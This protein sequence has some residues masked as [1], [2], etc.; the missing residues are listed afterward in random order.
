MNGAYYTN[1]PYEGS[2]GG[3]V[4]TAVAQP[5]EEGS[6]AGIWIIAVIV[7][8]VI[9]GL[10]LWFFYGGGGTTTPTSNSGMVWTIVNGAGTTSDTFTAAAGQA[11]YTASGATGNFALQ[12]VAP[13]NAKGQQFLIIND[14][15]ATITGTIQGGSP[16]AVA[17][18]RSYLGVWLSATA[19]NQINQAS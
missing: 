11:Y 8:L 10:I 3:G 19:V 5:E 16:I 13:A 2:Y 14:S 1:N 18:R 6:S 12:V 7:I 15:A 17:P 4:S 9:L